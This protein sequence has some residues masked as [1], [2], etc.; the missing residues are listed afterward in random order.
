MAD[1]EEGLVFRRADFERDL[2][3]GAD[4]GAAGIVGGRASGD[5]LAGTGRGAEGGRGSRDGR[6]RGWSLF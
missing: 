5:G 1:G 6:V 3:F 4:K 2:G